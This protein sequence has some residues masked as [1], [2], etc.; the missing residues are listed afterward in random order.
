[1]QLKMHKLKKSEANKCKVANM[2]EESAKTPGMSGKMRQTGSEESGSK[3]EYETNYSKASIRMKKRG[4]ERTPAEGERLS[5]FPGKEDTSAKETSSVMKNRTD[6]KKK[7][8]Q[9]IAAAGPREKQTS[10]RAKG[11]IRTS[12]EDCSSSSSE[13][14]DEEDIPDTWEQLDT[15]K[16]CLVK[17]VRAQVCE[18]DVQKLQVQRETLNSEEALS[19]KG[20][21]SDRSQEACEGERQDSQHRH[22][23]EETDGI[24]H[25]LKKMAKIDK[26]FMKTL[27]ALASTG[28][29]ETALIDKLLTEYTKLKGVALEATH[30]IAKLQGAVEIYQKEK[31]SQG[32]CYASVLAHKEEKRQANEAKDFTYQDLGMKISKPKVALVI[33]SDTMNK[34]EIRETVRNK[35]DPHVLG[36]QEPDMRLGREGVVVTSSSKQGI[37]KLEEYITKDRALSSQ[38]KVRRPRAKTL[39]VK[40]VGVEEDVDNTELIERLVTQ[41]NLSCTV[42]EMQ[43][44]AS[45]KGR[46][47]KSF[48]V[49][50]QLN[51]WKSIKDKT[52][53]NIGW[54]RC[55]V[56]DNTYVPRCSFCAKYGHT[57]RTCQAKAV[58]CTECG[59]RHHFT[60]CKEGEYEC[61]VCAEEGLHQEQQGHSMM[62]VRCPTY[63]KRRAEEREKIIQQLEFSQL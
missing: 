43:V 55:P 12:I 28:D 19:Q 53:L 4:L 34:E 9:E 6:N 49:S 22:E 31:Q 23:K 38:L 37:T 20:I 41:N 15:E 1:M 18:P 56:Y 61:C 51:A 57:Q 33:T 29:K 3:S 21:A 8:N 63:Q 39:E 52:H 14:S 17:H 27:L 42:Q 35:L 11:M 26:T 25:M 10:D 13:N 16:Q 50:L 62:S 54:S 24:S 44:K 36:L 60:E 32:P 46:N 47:G 5:S 7:G 45:W 48:I 30:E 40:I 2:C 58:K 59:G